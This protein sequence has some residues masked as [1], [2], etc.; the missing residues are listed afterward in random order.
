MKTVILPG[1]SK[2]HNEVWAEEIKNNMR[3]GHEILV[4]K[5]RH[6]T[7]DKS[8]SL[9]FELDKIKDEI[10]DEKVNILAKSVGVLVALKLIPKIF[11]QV[12]R[13][14]LC[15]IASVDSED[16]K[17]LLKAVLAKVNVKDILC[18]QNKKDEFVPFSQA[19]KF[20]HLVEPR[21]KVIS[22]PRSDHY[23]PYPE[24]FERFF[25][26]GD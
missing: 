19:E 10:G 26:S 17:D 12:K 3:L 21:L 18:I 13:V 4:H 11:S 6:W 5:W 8:F 25:L 24:D 22:K 23:Y 1:Y 14:I 15:G 7:E 16:R 20:Y 2:N 9:K